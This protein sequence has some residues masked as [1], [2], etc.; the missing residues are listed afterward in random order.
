MDKMI[1]KKYHE[2]KTFQL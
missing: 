2:K 1:L